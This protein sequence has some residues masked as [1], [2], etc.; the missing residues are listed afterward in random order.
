[1]V[2]PCAASDYSTVTSSNQVFGI[3]LSRGNLYLFTSTVACFIT[4]H[5][6][7]PVASAAAGSILVPAGT[8]ILIH[9]NQGAKV[10]VIR[11]TADGKATLT[12]VTKE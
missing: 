2:V 1:M 9:G 11:D 7:T 10:A 4:Q 3:S 5:A 12:P 6:D 8:S